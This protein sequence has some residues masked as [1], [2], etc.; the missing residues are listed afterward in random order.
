MINENRLKTGDKVIC[1]KTCIMENCPGDKRT[2]IG[3]VYKVYKAAWKP[4]IVDDSNHIHYFNDAWNIYFANP[5][6][7]KLKRLLNEK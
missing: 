1:I 2:T 7:L 4:Y 5:R 6:E 3:K